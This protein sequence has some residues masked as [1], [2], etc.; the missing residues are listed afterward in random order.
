[1]TETKGCEPK[2]ANLE[3]Q[4]ASLHMLDLKTMTWKSRDSGMKS[5]DDF[6]YYFNPSEEVLYV[7]GGFLSG[8]KSNDLWKYDV[9]QD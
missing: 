1:M 4:N 6:A 3:D 2:G 5:R 7:F 8:Y 9:T